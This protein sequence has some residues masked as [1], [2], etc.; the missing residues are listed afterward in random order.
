MRPRTLF[1]AAAAVAIAACD[2][3]AF[4]PIASVENEVDTITLGALRSTALTDPSAYSV[5]ARLAVRTDQV[6]GPNFDFVY[7]IDSARGPAFYPAEVTGVLPKSA[8]NPGLKRTATPFDSLTIA[9]LNG[10]ISDSLV[11]I[12]SG[13]V[14]LARSQ[15]TCAQGVP[16]YAK[17][18]V[19]SIDAAAHTVTFRVLSDIN[20]GFRGLKPGLPK[21]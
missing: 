3:S 19:L 6:I 1:F 5:T 15:I 18:E 11:P 4:N 21:A 10:Y 2:N 8:T 14:F 12:D 13:D 7:D 20:C 16:N 9:D 17:L